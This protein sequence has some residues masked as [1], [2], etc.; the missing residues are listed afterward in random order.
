[1]GLASVN[2]LTSSPSFGAMIF[3]D[4]IDR[5]Y[6][7]DVTFTVPT[8]LRQVKDM[9]NERDGPSAAQPAKAESL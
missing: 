9:I 7:G 6:G 1:M 5:A 4:L 2:H 3:Q 8:D